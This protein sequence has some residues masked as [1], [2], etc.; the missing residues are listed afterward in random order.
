MQELGNSALGTVLGVGQIGS[1]GGDKG[2]GLYVRLVSDARAVF[3]LVTAHIRIEYD[4]GDFPDVGLY[5]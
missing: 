1:N 5:L 2:Y 4:H 3:L